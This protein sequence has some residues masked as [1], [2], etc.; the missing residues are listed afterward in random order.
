M[1]TLTLT[2]PWTGRPHATMT[3]AE[4]L[5]TTADAAELYHVR[6]RTARYIAARAAEQARAT[7]AQYPQKLGNNYVAPAS[8]W[9]QLLAPANKPR[10]GRPRRPAS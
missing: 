9:A 4:Q 1:Q 10:A 6:P 3:T 5:Y 8:V 2:S 7:G